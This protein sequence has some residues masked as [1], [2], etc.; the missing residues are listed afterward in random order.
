MPCRSVLS[1]FGYFVLSRTRTHWAW[2]AF[3][4]FIF[5]FN[6]VL[7]KLNSLVL[8]KRTRCVFCIRNCVKA[9]ENYRSLWLL[10][11][12]LLSNFSKAFVI[13]CRTHPCRRI[14]GSAQTIQLK[15]REIQVRWAMGFTALWLCD[16]SG[17]PEFAWVLK[18][19]SSTRKG[20]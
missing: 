11:G 14:S 20:I 7:F 1:W 17:C 2:Y 16:V 6:I 8:E 5:F 15:G 19:G 12:L 10:K 9:L 13:R 18:P 3:I 4:M